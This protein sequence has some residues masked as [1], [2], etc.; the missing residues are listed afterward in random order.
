MKNDDEDIIDA[1]QAVQEGDQDALLH[2]LKSKIILPNTI[3]VDGCSLLHWAAINNRLNIARLLLA[4]GSN[5]LQSGGVLNEIPLQWAIRKK[6]MAMVKLLINWINSNSGGSGGGSSSSIS[7]SMLS[8]KNKLGNDSLHIAIRSYDINTIFLLLLWGSNPNTYDND[9]N[10]PLLWII[11]NYK[12][13]NKSI[14]GIIR[15]LLKY[16]SDTSL[17]DNESNNALHILAKDNNYDNDIA[18]LIYQSMNDITI[19]NININNYTPRILA[20]HSNNPRFVQF[21]IDAYLYNILPYHFTTLIGF[22]TIIVLPIL[23][24]IYDIY[25]GF[26]YTL[27]IWF[28]LTQFGYQWTIIKHQ[29]R[30][31]IGITIG[32]IISIIISY[33]YYIISFIDSYSNIIFISSYCLSLSIIVKFLLTKPLIAVPGDPNDIADKIVKGTIYLGPNDNDNDID[34]RNYDFTI[35]KSKDTTTPIAKPHKVSITSIDTL[36]ALSTLSISTH[37]QY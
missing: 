4:W 12:D 16:G 9:G 3:D 32:L 35:M 8:H 11:K 22:L 28:F 10:T 18:F 15:L 25:I 2:A 21:I 7:S 1:V 36:L 37:Y 5:P 20:I 30:I 27:L 26:F 23:V 14:K 33:N 24:H 17:V 6:Y 19:N 34:S 29:D 13:H 31:I